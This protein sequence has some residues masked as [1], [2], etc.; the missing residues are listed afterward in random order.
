MHGRGYR[1][2]AE[3]TARAVDDTSADPTGLTDVVADVQAGR[4]RA[5]VVGAPAGRARRDLLDELYQDAAAAGILVARGRMVRRGPLSGVVEA[6]DELVQR[7]PALLE[8]L[9]EGCQVELR[10]VFDGRSPSTIGRLQLAARELVRR[11]RGGSGA[12]GAAGPG[13]GRSPH[14]DPRRAVGPA[15]PACPIGLVVAHREPRLLSGLEIVEPDGSLVPADPGAEVLVAA[16]AAFARRDWATAY[17]GFAGADGL[18]PADLTPSRSRRTGSAGARRSPSA[19]RPRTGPTS[20][21]GRPTGR[22]TRPSW[23]R[24]TSGSAATPPPP[25]AGCHGPTESWPTSPRAPSTAIRCTWR[26]PG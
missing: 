18:E 7:R 8:G 21:R 22:A 20:T 17:E 9:P 24:S 23:S 25:T 13:A 6:L 10:S 5:V 16:R 3:P 2:V 19:I 12:G 14:A 11:G 1:F 26:P 15:E 4:G